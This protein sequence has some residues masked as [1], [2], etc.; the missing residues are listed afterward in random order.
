MINIT[1][2]TIIKHKI[3]NHKCSKDLLICNHLCE[4]Q[5]WERHKLHGNVMHTTSDSIAGST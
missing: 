2:Q 4:E 1:T 5:E 3:A